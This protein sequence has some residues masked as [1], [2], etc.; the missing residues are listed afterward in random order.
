MPERI[1]KTPN[2]HAL[3]A[4]VVLEWLSVTSEGLSAD[5]ATNRLQRHGPNQ[6]P[7]SAQ[8]GPLRRLLAQFH[9]LLIYVLLIAGSITLLLK[10]RVDAAV[11]FGVVVI[12]AMIGFLQ[13]GRAERAIRAIR[14]MLSPQATVRRDGNMRKI[15]A[16]DLVPGDIVRLEAGDRVP[17]D[18]RLL[19]SH[20]LRS[21]ESS[22]TGESLPVDKQPSTLAVNTALADRCNMVFSGSLILAGQGL[23]VVIATAEDTEL[24]HINALL[25]GIETLTTPLLRQIQKL[26]QLLTIAILLLA[27]LTFILGVWIYHQYIL[28]MFLSTVAF[29]VAAIPEGLPA[30]ITITLAIGVRRMAERH[31][32]IRRLPAVETL[33]AVSV[34]C[35]DKTGTLTLNEM[36]VVSLVTADCH[37]TVEAHGYAPE[38]HIKA[39]NDPTAIANA[40]D[41]AELLR[42]GV[43]CNDGNVEL[44][45]NLWVAVG[46]PI[47]AALIVLA[48]KQG[49]DITHEITLWPRLDAIPFD[50]SQQMMAT[51]HHDHK[52]Q[53]FIALKGAPER[54]IMRCSSQR[55][56]GMDNPLDALYWQTWL[57]RLADEGQRMLAFAMRPMPTMT[58]N[59]LSHAALEDGFSLLGFAG[60]ID[61]PREEAA[62]AVARAI[63]AGIS[64]KMITGDHPRTAAAIAADL[65]IDGNH[66]PLTG[67]EL[68]TLDPAT[69]GTAVRDTAVFARMAPAH[70]LRL[71]EALQQD[72]HVIAMTGDGV[73]DAPALKR[74]DVGIAM[75]LK[76]T[77]T[78]KEAAEMVIADDNFSTIVAGIEEGRAAY[79]NIRKSVLFI[80]PTNGAEALVIM[81]AVIADTLLP[82]SAVQILWVNMITAVTLS[83]ALA[84]ERPEAGLMLRPPRP[85]N[86]SLITGLLLRRIALVSIS[87]LAS[88]DVTF[89]S[90]LALGASLD[91]ARTAAVNML[92]MGEMVYLLSVRRLSAGM[93]HRNVMR[94]NPWI[95][96]ALALTA[97]IQ[98]LFTY[99]APMQ[100]LFATSSLP[101]KAW[102]PMLALTAL[103]YLLIE[104]EKHLWNRRLDRKR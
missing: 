5:E 69:M 67:S 97:I 40:G 49:L 83:L 42:I 11:I 82:I 20:G 72:Q 41:L 70:K 59:S 15:D 17:A 33:G 65:G 91:T 10:H 76:G 53:R 36:T 35:S 104:L 77:E 23:G 61:P 96:L 62:D 30:I 19:Q 88:V 24:G 93:H 81:S 39:M 103:I 38:G 12:N 8:R 84:F 28:D 60:F 32:I 29:A 87:L 16:Q 101:W 48:R 66:P 63:R 98:L 73:N 45:G 34:I 43:L 79:D 2:W 89:Y 51:L 78:A 64:V 57:E 46:D 25:A 7:P 75:G 37:Y 22:L 99:T 47:D 27:G 100:T 56:D 86:E 21:D 13:E 4:E 3:P 54:V 68:D 85:A 52:G 90:A 31:V 102:P 18:L 95:L 44:H 1:E 71:I 50:P 74:A 55:H 58:T 92:V 14:A 9:N 94:D 26:A 80:L 6:L